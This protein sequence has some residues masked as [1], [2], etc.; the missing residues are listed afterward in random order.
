M[1]Y[2]KTFYINGVLKLNSIF[3]ASTVKTLKK[4]YKVVE[5]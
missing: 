1:T 5:K 2:K 4:I 3:C